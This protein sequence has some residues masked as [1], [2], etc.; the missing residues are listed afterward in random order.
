MVQRQSVFAGTKTLWELYDQMTF[1]ITHE[2][3]R[4]SESGR[5]AKLS[6]LQFAFDT[7]KAAA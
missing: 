4:L 6:A 7:Y 1:A 5:M 2:F 3:K